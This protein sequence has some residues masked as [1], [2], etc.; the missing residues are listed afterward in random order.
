VWS[1]IAIEAE[2]C[3]HRVDYRV[4]ARNVGE[5]AFELRRARLDRGAVVVVLSSD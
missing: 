5:R 2:L 4:G 1:S 3:N